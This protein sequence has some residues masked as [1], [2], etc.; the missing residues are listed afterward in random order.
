VREIAAKWYV[1]GDVLLLKVKDRLETPTASEVFSLVFDGDKEFRGQAITIDDVPNGLTFSRYPV[2]VNAVIGYGGHQANT[3]LMCALSVTA[4]GSTVPLHSLRERTADHIVVDG[5]WF[6]FANG[7]REE[8]LDCF[9][10]AGL[11]DAGALTFRQYL[12]LRAQAGKLPWL[13]DAT[14]DQIIHPGM[15][16]APND[17]A[18]INFKGT[19]YPYQR[20]GWQWLSFICREGLGAILADQMGLGKTVQIIA[21]LAAPERDRVV[22]SLVVAPGTLLENWRREIKK[23]AP[24][25]STYIHQGSGRT[26]DYRDLLELDVII[27]SYDTVIRD[28]SM[29]RMVEWRIVIL[30]EAQSIKNPDTKRANSVK[31]LRRA[32]GIAVT[33]TPVQNRLRDLWSIVDFC[34]PGY[35]GDESSFERR[36]DE[37]MI[38]A[39]TLEP[40]VS[41]IMLRRR[42][43]EVAQDLPPRIE[44]PQVLTF[45]DS[46]AKEYERIRS[47][48]I[49]EYGG[50]ATLVALGRLR[51]FCAHPMLL[52]PALVTVEQALT[53]G[54]F[55][56][57]LEIADEVFENK[58]KM[59]VFTSYNRMAG[60]IVQTV[61]QRYGLYADVINGDTAIPDRQKIIDEFTNEPAGA[62]LALNPRAAG[63]G[64]NI[65][66]AT[67][68]VHYNLE[69]NPAVED[70][71]SARA[72]RRG[73]DRPVTIHRLFYAD[74]VE[75]VVDDR[76]RRK[77][78]LSEAAVV[79]VPGLDDD[80][81]DIMC[82]LQ[83]SPLKRDIA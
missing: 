64:L 39:G 40:F 44:I 42:V 55:Q 27:T 17:D 69:W 63:T 24:T 1:S 30:D 18:L 67:H 10:A 80:Y 71:A 9:A 59:L 61:R 83:S 45:E 22:P 19:L 78:Q 58:E 2:R 28:S 50:G 16:V 3:G 37:S 70:Q 14:E 62:L 74:S 48:T 33:G 15:N 25:I 29:F 82:A 38:G 49:R 4:G 6:P 20:N 11:L 76:L 60:F 81:A 73:Q 5:R 7:V 12:T 65:T 68:V 31:R 41:P 26:G 32:V 51:M 46:E 47:E 66:A 34:I 54:K 77:R 21:L 75:E 36:F 13:R 23:F 8:I 52:D 79:G 72:H 56:R 35:L 57:L 43:S 53:F